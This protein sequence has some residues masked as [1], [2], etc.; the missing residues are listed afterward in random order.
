MSTWLEIQQSQSS[1][2]VGSSTAAGVGGSTRQNTRRTSG[3]VARNKRKPTTTKEGS[4]GVAGAILG[5][6]GPRFNRFQSVN[7]SALQQGDPEVGSASG[8][9]NNNNN[10]LS[11]SG[12][13]SSREEDIFPTSSSNTTPPRRKLRRKMGR[14]GY[15]MRD[16]FEE[17]R[18]MPYCNLA[19]LNLHYTRAIWRFVTSRHLAGV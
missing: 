13:D 18:G 12:D 11:V 7:Y 19:Q 6:F 1:T 2:E 4:G 5:T 15:S 17:G 8:S 9:K 14:R 16:A 10:Y 3:G